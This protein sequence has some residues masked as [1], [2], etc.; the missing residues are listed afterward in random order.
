M[1]VK[2]DLEEAAVGW[3]S[4]TLVLVALIYLLHGISLFQFLFINSILFSFIHFIFI[5]CN[6]SIFYL[7]IIYL[8]N[9]SINNL[10]IIYLFINSNRL[11][12]SRFE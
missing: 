9:I 10:L 3:E 2:E 6:F 12:Y 1:V 7:L 8:F 5:F 11:K 4:L